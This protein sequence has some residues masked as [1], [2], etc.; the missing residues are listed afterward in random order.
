MHGIV[1]CVKNFDDVTLSIVIVVLLIG[2][3]L[4]M[5]PH[6]RSS[7]VNLQKG[8]YNYPITIF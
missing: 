1:K 8:F 4:L 7:D 2:L 5:Q 3:A 6:K